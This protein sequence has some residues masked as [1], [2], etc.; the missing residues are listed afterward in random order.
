LRV[1]LCRILADI[2]AALKLLFNQGGSRTVL[3][4]PIIDVSAGGEVKMLRVVRI[5][6]ISP[7]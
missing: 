5:L 1:N 4:Q 7:H 6:P 3:A 2:M